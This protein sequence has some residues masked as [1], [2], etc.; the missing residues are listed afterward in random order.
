[1]TDTFTPDRTYT[2]DAKGIVAEPNKQPEVLALLGKP[3]L[4]MRYVAKG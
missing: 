4:G 3:K 2:R 1:M